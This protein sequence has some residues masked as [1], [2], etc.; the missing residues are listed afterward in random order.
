M[1]LTFKEKNQS[2]EMGDSEAKKRWLSIPFQK[3]A[4]CLTVTH[5]FVVGHLASLEER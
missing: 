5:I 2:E 1:T 3:L 4:S